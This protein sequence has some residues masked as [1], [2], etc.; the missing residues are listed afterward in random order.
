MQ[1]NYQAESY[2]LDKNE[3]EDICSIIP[4][5]NKRVLLSLDD[6]TAEQRKLVKLESQKTHFLFKCLGRIIEK[7]S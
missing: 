5:R 2:W 3:E 6:L 7:E 1:Q 4:E